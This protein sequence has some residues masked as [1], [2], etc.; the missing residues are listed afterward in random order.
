MT[1]PDAPKTD[2]RK[3][4]FY[5]PES[6]VEEIRGEAIRLDRSLSWIVQCAWRLARFEPRAT[7]Q[8]D[9]VE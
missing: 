1:P 6:M 5:F 2:K 4:T 8:V 7:P 9:D 3:Q